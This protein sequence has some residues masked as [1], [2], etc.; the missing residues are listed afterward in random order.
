MPSKVRCN[1]FPTQSRVEM[2]V[3]CTNCLIPLGSCRSAV[4]SNRDNVAKCPFKA[5]GD[6]SRSLDVAS[7]VFTNRVCQA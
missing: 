6:T 2:K 3:I 5:T 4:G 1:P 7:F